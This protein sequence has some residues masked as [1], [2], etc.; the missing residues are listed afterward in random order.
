MRKYS[1]NLGQ[2]DFETEKFAI[3]SVVSA[4]HTSEMD[5]Q[6]QND[7]IKK[8]KNSG[9]AD[10]NNNQGGEMNNQPQDNQPQDNQDS[11]NQ[12]GNNQQDNNQ[13]DK[14]N[15]NNEWVSE[16]ISKFVENEDMTLPEIKPIVKPNVKPE[17]KP[18]RRSKPFRVPVIEP[19]TSPAPKAEK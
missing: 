5:Q 6:D 18:H 17:T 2:P 12:D 15:L 14:I 10:Q 8:I 3:N 4:T 16:K 9:A 19:G 11:N 13:N 7:I 1:K